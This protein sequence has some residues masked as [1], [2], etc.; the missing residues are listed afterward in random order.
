MSEEKKD[1]KNKKAFKFET[2]IP[3]PVIDFKGKAAKK[4]FE[5]IEG[6]TI[7]SS[8]PAYEMRAIHKALRKIDLEVYLINRH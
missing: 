2:F 4:S 7:L 8:F 1:S 6:A 5:D 3:M